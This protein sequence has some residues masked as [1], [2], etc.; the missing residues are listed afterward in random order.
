MFCSETILVFLLGC[1]VKLG[2]PNTTVDIDES[3][4][5][6]RK[7][8]R[9][10]PVKVQWV[11]GGVE[12][13]S[14]KTFLFSVPDRTGDTLMTLRRDWIEPGTTVINDSWATYR[15]LGDQGYTQRTVNHSIQFV[16]PETRA[17]TNTIESTWLS[18]KVFLG[19]YNREEDYSF[20]LAHYML[21][22]RCRAK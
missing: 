11:F 14:C 19:Q 18:V 17:H 15:D 8:H 21:A 20:H 12:R 1:S 2:G 5:G 16:N 9:G 13:V 10:Q 3:K 4:L 6:R 22:A 7:C